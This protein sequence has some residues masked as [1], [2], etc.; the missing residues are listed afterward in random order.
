MLSGECNHKICT[1]SRVSNLVRRT[2]FS[3]W[4]SSFDR[5]TAANCELVLELEKAEPGRVSDKSQPELDVDEL[6]RPGGFKL[7]L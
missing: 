6:R 5:Y 4:S 7:D 1:Y 3:F 2:K